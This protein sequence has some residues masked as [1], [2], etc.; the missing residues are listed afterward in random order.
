L[1]YFVLEYAIII[2]N[3]PLK[4][5][6]KSQLLLLKYIFMGKKSR[7]LKK[8]AKRSEV[9]GSTDRVSGSTDQISE[10][11]DLV[12]GSTDQISESTDRISGPMDQASGPTSVQEAL[13]PPRLPRTGSA[14]GVEGAMP[15]AANPGNGNGYLLAL[16][17][18]FVAVLRIFKFWS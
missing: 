10:S 4:R 8:A 5:L 6:C 14:I 1:K 12:S 18:G 17:F 11:T 7:K 9:S 13:G 2:H 3:R 16:L 15:V